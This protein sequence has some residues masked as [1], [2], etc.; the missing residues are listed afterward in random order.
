MLLYFE[1]K[2]SLFFGEYFMQ[3]RHSEVSWGF[4]RDYSLLFFNSSNK[5]SLPFEVGLEGRVK[6]QYAEVKVILHLD[7]YEEPVENFYCFDNFLS[8]ARFLKKMGLWQIDALKEMS[9]RVWG[10]SLTEALK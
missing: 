4:A 5:I 8:F 7:E 6:K 10:I 2:Y 1:T 3:T 9:S